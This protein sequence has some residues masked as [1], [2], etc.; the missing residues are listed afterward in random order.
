MDR[1]HGETE[2]RPDQKLAY[3]KPKLISYGSMRDL[4]KTHV[5]SHS[6]DATS[7]YN[8]ATS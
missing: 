2:I 4:T 7:P 3:Q 8:T 6:G 1:K 5:G